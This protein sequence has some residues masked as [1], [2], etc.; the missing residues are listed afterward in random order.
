MSGFT[1]EFVGCMWTE[2][3]YRKKV[4]SKISGYVWTG[5]TFCNAVLDTNVMWIVPRNTCNPFKIYGKLACATLKVIFKRLNVTL[6]IGVYLDT[7][8][9]SIF[10]QNTDWMPLN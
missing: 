1:V 3:I 7:F 8:L 5:P 4:D 6:L 10:I 9:L 2:A